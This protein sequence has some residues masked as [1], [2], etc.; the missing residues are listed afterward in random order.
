MGFKYF[1][2]SSY[3]KPYVNQSNS[4]PLSNNPNP[5]NY[6]IVDS[7][8]IKDYLLLKIKYHDCTSY[9]G[10]KVL[11]FKCSLKDLL[12]QKS[13]DPHFSDNKDYI[14]PIARFEPT[15]QGWE[16]GIKLAKI[17]NHE[18]IQTK[19]GAEIHSSIF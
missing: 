12:K 19:G 9:E 1:S 13:I 11:L 17:L 16:N 5:N 14:S 8:T 4:T 10:K 3:D 15:E 2:T 7:K 6:L 18:S